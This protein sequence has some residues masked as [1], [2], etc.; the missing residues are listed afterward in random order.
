VAYGS[1]WGWGYYG[2]NNPYY[3]GG[4]SYF[5]Y[6]QPI[7]AAP[8][9]PDQMLV[10]DDGGGPGPD[11][12]GLADDSAQS[13]MTPE[14]QQAMQIFAGA[15]QQFTDGD[16]TGA[17]SAINNAIRLDADDPVMHEFRALC[18]FAQ[19]NYRDAA[20]AM[21]AV[22]SG[23]PG[24]DWTTEAGLYPSVTVYTK[25]LRALEQYSRENPQAADA[26]F[27]LAYQYLLTGHNDAAS[28]EL[29][30]VVALQPSD[31]LASQLLKSIGGPADDTSSPAPL[32]DSSPAAP[33]AGKPVDATTLVGNWTATRP[34]GSKVQMDLTSGKKFTWSFDQEGKPQELKGDYSLADNYLVLKAG[35]QKALIGQ[36][37]LVGNNEMNFRLADKNP[38]DPGLV[39]KR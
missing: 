13:N 17:L 7:V 33:P 6:A 34:D 38:A 16:Y 26:R 23:G 4:G 14:Q 24:W 39:F 1:P 37:G 30:Q 25:Q 10:A 5:S 20:A 19:G 8:L 2:F 31:T 22:L 36:V 11:P 12:A 15:R 27:L 28:A 3:A 9:Y 32:P 18:L 35:E 21:Y 29:K